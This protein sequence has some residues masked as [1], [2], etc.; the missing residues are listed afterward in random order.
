MAKMSNKGSMLSGMTKKSPPGDSGM[1][2][3][4]GKIGADPI[5]SS[6]AKSHSLGPR[7]A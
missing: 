3:P 6:V 7:E 5:R 2:P 4:G 1:R